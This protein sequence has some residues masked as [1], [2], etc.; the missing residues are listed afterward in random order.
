MSIATQRRETNINKELQDMQRAANNVLSQ[1]T[2][3][4]ERSK[5]YTAWSHDSLAKGEPEMDQGEVDRYTASLSQMIAVVRS[6]DTVFDEMTGVQGATDAETAANLAAF[7]S[8][9]NLQM[10]VYSKSFD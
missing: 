8:K 2:A 10:E 3:V 1:M 9:Y 5:N 4:I 7:I 6:F